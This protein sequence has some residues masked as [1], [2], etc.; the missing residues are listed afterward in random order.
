MCEWLFG[1]PELNV[2]DRGDGHILQVRH[3]LRRFYARG[4]LTFPL[5]FLRAL[6]E[7][8]SQL[9]EAEGCEGD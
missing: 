1:L 4:S 8:V 6:L 5:G 3:F 7:E 2:V 9:F